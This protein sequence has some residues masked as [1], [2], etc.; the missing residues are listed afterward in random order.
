M[1]NRTPSRQQPKKKETP[2]PM[3]RHGYDDVHE[4]IQHFYSFFG[5]EEAEKIL[6]KF[7][8]SWLTADEII[9]LDRNARDVHVVFY[10]KLRILLEASYLLQKER[11][12]QGA[13]EH[14]VMAAWK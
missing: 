11:I 13:T 1:P 12:E 10:E 6:Y 4:A 3:A 8:R 9:C 2:N 14:H 7:F 5:K